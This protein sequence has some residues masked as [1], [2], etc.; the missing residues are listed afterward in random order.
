[1]RPVK[2]F[3]SLFSITVLALQSY[4]VF[5]TM[6]YNNYYWPFVNYPMYSNS[7][8]AGETFSD[9]RLRALPCDNLR[10]TLQLGE[11]DLHVTSGRFN[12]LIYGSAGVRGTRARSETNAEA[13][14]HFITTYVPRPICRVQV[15][16]QLYRIGA[17]GLEYPGRPWEIAKEWIVTPPPAAS[18]DSTGTP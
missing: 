10:D 18:I 2:I 4:A 11:D 3:V 9:V 7:H 12:G 8:Q 14:L 1:V 17:K 15:W 6:G 5:S 16:E 13:L